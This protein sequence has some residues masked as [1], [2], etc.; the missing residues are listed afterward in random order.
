MAKTK[1]TMVLK[2]F[3][4]I[5]FKSKFGSLHLNQLQIRLQTNYTKTYPDLLMELQIEITIGTESEFPWTGSSSNPLPSYGW[6]FFNNQQSR[7]RSL[8]ISLSDFLL[9]YSRMELNAKL[10]VFS[11]LKNDN[12]IYSLIAI[13]CSLSIEKWSWWWIPPLNLLFIDLQIW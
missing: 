5:S 13:L 9:F 4:I 6:A 8:I 10:K 7:S 3:F 11:Y 12:E 1:S 2:E